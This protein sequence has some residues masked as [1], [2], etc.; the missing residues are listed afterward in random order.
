LTKDTDVTVLQ[1]GDSVIKFL[2]DNAKDVKD[3]FDAK[4][5]ARGGE[6]VVYWAAH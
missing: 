4:E 1:T 2:S 5:L 6:A 3:V